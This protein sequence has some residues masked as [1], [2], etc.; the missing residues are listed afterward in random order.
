LSFK[1]DEG[2]PAEMVLPGDKVKMEVELIQ[3]IAIEMLNLKSI[4]N[5]IF[6]FKL[7]NF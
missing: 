5:V 6:F 7:F 1:T 3:P 4:L 2:N